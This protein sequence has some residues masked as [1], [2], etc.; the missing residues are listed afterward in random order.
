MEHAEDLAQPHVVH[1]EPSPE[2]DDE[3]RGTR[4]ETPYD[5]DFV[6]EIKDGWPHGERLWDPDEEVW[7]VH[8]GSEAEVEN[9]VIRH[10]GG[11]RVVH[12]DGSEKLRDKSGDY[13]Q[14]G[15]FS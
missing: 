4:L 5:S 7:W 3:R 6:A 10:F 15:L 1:D 2:P 9:M 11:A 12:E 13:E 14:G 8:A